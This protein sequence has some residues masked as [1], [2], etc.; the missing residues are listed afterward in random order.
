MY[1]L[2]GSDLKGFFRWPTTLLISFVQFF[3]KNSTVEKIYC[4]IRDDAVIC[5]EKHQKSGC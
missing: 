5:N 3:I 1:I 2:N 4:P